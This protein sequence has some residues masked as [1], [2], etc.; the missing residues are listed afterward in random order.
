M[1]YAIA[2]YEEDLPLEE[3]K[4]EWHGEIGVVRSEERARKR[5]YDLA[6]RDLGGNVHVYYGVTDDGMS[7]EWLRL[8]REAGG[9]EAAPEAGSDVASADTGEKA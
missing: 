2:K 8:I 4:I 7:E 1:E 6:Q 5:R 9:E 3:M